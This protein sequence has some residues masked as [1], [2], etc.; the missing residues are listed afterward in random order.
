[1]DLDFLKIILEQKNTCFTQFGRQVTGKQGTSSM[2]KIMAIQLTSQKFVLKY[3]INT[4]LG[5]DFWLNKIKKTL[6]K[7]S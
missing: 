3:I 7:T 5:R 1:M 4:K 6:I 2:T